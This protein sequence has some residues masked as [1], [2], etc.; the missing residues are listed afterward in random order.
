ML[1]YFILASLVLL[2]L[3]LNLCAGSVA[4][5]LREIPGILLGR[6]AD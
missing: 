1:S 6:E 2:F 4:V 3:A 5:P